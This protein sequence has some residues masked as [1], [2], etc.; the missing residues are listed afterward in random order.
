MD[1][2]KRNL[3]IWMMDKM[4]E[5]IKDAE[6]RYSVVVASKLA[7]DEIISG[8]VTTPANIANA[9]WRPRRNPR[10]SGISEFKPKNGWV[11]GVLFVKGISGINKYA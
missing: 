6:T 2:H 10:N 3:V 8:G 4:P 7:V 9:C 11:L 5:V 1:F